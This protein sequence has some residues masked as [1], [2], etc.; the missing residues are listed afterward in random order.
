VNAGEL[1][2]AVAD[3]HPLVVE[4][5][6]CV[7]MAARVEPRLLRRA[8]LELVPQ[9]DAGTEADLWFSPLVDS[10][11]VFGVTLEPEIAEILRE[12]LAGNPDRA[13]ASYDLI[14]DVHGDVPPTARLFEDLT[15]LSVRAG[16]GAVTDY[17]RELERAVAVILGDPSRA[18][19]LS[20][21][22]VS[23]LPA[24]PAAVRATRSAWRLWLAST[25]RLETATGPGGDPPLE[26]LRDLL[27]EL[28]PPDDPQV[29]VGVV[30]TTGGIELSAP[31]AVDAALVSVPRSNPL[32]LDFSLDESGPAVHEGLR[33]DS[34]RR[35]R[36][37]AVRPTAGADDWARP[38]GC[39]APVERVAVAPE[40]GLLAGGRTDGQVTVW[41]AEGTVVAEA[42]C[43]TGRAVAL[44]LD[45]KRLMT[46]SP[47]GHPLIRDARTGEV[48]EELPAHPGAVSAIGYA[49]DGDTFAFGTSAGV[50]AIG[51]RSTETPE[52]VVDIALSMAADVAAVAH[53]A[54]VLLLSAESL[55]PIGT[56]STE[57]G[58]VRAVAFSPDG[59]RLAIAGSER[60]SVWD[61]S[62]REALAYLK[63]GCHDVAWNRAGNLL[64]AVGTD[65]SLRVWDMQSGRQV[66][67]QDLATDGL[68]VAFARHDE[69]LV[70]GGLPSEVEIRT[71]TGSVW[72]LA[73][74]ERRALREELQGELVALLDFL[75]AIARG[76]PHPREP[77]REVEERYGRGTVLSEK[78]FDALR[79]AAESALKSAGDVV[80]RELVRRSDWENWVV[81]LVQQEAPGFEREEGVAKSVSAFLELM[82]LVLRE[83]AKHYGDVLFRSQLRPE[84]PDRLELL[85]VQAPIDPGYPMAT[86]SRTPEEGYRPYIHGGLAE[87]VEAFEHAS[88]LAS[89]RLPQHE[90]LPVE[91]ID[92]DWRA[93]S[94]SESASSSSA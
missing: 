21:W 2:G 39:A 62:T 1:V 60:L 7:S 72:R 33:P 83:G 32:L 20:R 47:D 67:F 63:T 23:A 79:W 24:L 12:R 28:S 89:V 70:V 25:S 93:G 40:A 4:L 51:E 3:E 77:R 78:A 46:G 69:S 54:D 87:V 10:R 30:L 85:G 84:T 14:R 48:A 88:A 5:G 91:R 22:V 55:R 49:P 52:P 43:G 44:D 94:R 68:A 16:D 13:Q 71:A 29:P 73:A 19:A 66:G 18:T 81:L 76:F 92:L 11:T 57:L 50:V 35:V 56:F 59:S 74:R 34:T 45:G 41:D 37:G 65:R 86:K 38:L 90:S 8:R 53:R 75:D 27:P 9:A 61:V 31:P 6:E 42:P 36:L 15:W 82:G 26:L 17:E 58:G 64:A 80:R